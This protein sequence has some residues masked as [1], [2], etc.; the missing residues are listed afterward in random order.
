MKKSFKKHIRAAIC[1]LLVFPLCLTA[2]ADPNNGGSSGSSGS[3]GEYAGAVAGYAKAS[4]VEFWGTYSSSKII[5]G[6]VEGNDELKLPA[7]VAV[8][9]IGGE[10]EATQ[11]I[12][13]TGD[14]AVKE[15]DVIVSDLQGEGT[16]VFEKANI[17]VYH[18]RYIELLIGKEYYSDGGFYPDCLVP[19]ENVKEL[20]ETGIAKNNNQGLY[21]SFDVPENQP[22]GT[23]TGTIK[24]VIGGETKTIPVTL[25]VASVSIGVETHVKSL[26]LNE[27]YYH[28]G[29]LDTTEAMF[30]TYNKFLF[31]YRIGCNNVTNRSSM[32]T[33]ANTII[34]YAQIPECPGYNIPWDGYSYRGTGYVLNGRQLDHSV[35]YSVDAMITRFKML[36]QKGLKAGV[37]PFKKG[38]IYGFDEP[39]LA[40]G[41]IDAAIAVK[42][43][44][45]IVKQCKI[46]ASEELRAETPSEQQEFLE[47]ILESLEALPHLI[48]S[49]T[50]LDCELDL[51]VEDAAYCP[52]F[53]HLQNDGARER[54]R[55]SD[56]NELWWY[57]CVEPDY[58]YPTYH[59]DD[60]VLSA[61]LESWMKADY[62][63]QGNLYW[64][65]CQYWDSSLGYLEDYYSG[66]A[67][68]CLNTSGE[69]FLLYPGARYGIY[70]PLSSIRLEHIRDGLEEYE[71][72]YKLSE[73]YDTVSNQIGISFNED[74]IMS[75]LYESMYSGT[76]ISVTSEKFEFNRS[77]LISLL[78]LASSKAQVCIMSSEIK[79]NA[80][81]FQVFVKS[82]YQL[83]QAG[84]L[85][86]EKRAVEGGYVYT[87][88]VVLGD[89]NKLNLSVEIDGVTYGYSQGLGGGADVYNAKY[90]SDNNIVQTRR[91]PVTASLVDARTVNSSAAAGTKYVKLSL[92]DAEATATQD[93]LLKN[94][95]LFHSLGKT[96]DKLL[97]GIYNASSDEVPVQLYIDYGNGLGRYMKYV[98]QTLKPGMNNLSIDNLSG[99]NWK[100][101]KYINSLRIIVGNAGD[102]ARD[103]LYLTE[104]AV[105]K[106]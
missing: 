22:A 81:E 15:Y 87:V 17:N 101:I 29:E 8:R 20:G 99:M 68:R 35:S 47:V 60:T 73:I 19:F 69:G 21:I 13:T 10:E 103:Y 38:A 12:M 57:G 42:E 25:E 26:F 33:W 32:D 31:D 98:E 71:M 23:Y 79:G 44:A 70:G 49:S 27:W 90:I 7:E 105:H 83:K 104:I 67:S 66:N 59:I 77:Q 64:S 37:D 72:I 50:F 4:D 11:I 5:Q 91:V 85:V 56:E 30:D 1:A 84:G 96:D 9:A 48:L 62:N 63:I 41:S 75:F 94:D 43:W 53:Q 61:R 28:H 16:S 24:I 82:G 95:A 97:L 36:A 54:Y 86:T 106:L 46:I 55:L 74:D 39:D 3:E 89:G 40:L 80:Y 14:K 45:Y 34:E 78:E 51:S 2:C 88:N 92:A 76:K 52:E 6:K 102:A 93:F 58:P 65:T 100:K 18:E